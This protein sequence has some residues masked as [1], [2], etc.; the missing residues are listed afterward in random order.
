[1]SRL[2]D[3]TVTV[4]A[5]SAAGCIL[6]LAFIVLVTVLGHVAEVVLRATGVA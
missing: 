5:F 2:V 6:L 1:M 3:N 4:L